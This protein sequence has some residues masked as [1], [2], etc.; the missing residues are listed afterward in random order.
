MKEGKRKKKII[1]AQIGKAMTG[2]DSTKELCGKEVNSV[3]LKLSLFIAYNTVSLE[4]NY[5][6]MVP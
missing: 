1:D 5:L 6:C 2:L 3:L 4:L